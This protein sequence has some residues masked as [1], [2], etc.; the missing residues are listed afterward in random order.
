MKIPCRTCSPEEARASFASAATCPECVPNREQWMREAL[1]M[2]KEIEW[3]GHDVE[4]FPCCPSCERGSNSH[5][6]DCALA[7]LIRQGERL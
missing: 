6:A 4:T 2:L 1:K 5:H 3:S 7:R